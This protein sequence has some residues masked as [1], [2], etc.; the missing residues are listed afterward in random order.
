MFTHDSARSD[1]S[2]VRIKNLPIAAMFASLVEVVKTKCRRCLQ[3]HGM[4][5][6]I[7]L[8]K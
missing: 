4:R 3:F 8:Q 5:I 6:E 1:I 7:S 2:D